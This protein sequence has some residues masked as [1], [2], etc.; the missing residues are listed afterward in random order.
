MEQGRGSLDLVV[1]QRWH[2]IGLRLNLEN[3]TN[4][5]YLFTQGTDSQERAQREFKLG[6]TVSVSLSYSLF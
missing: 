4:S 1:S 3:L 6:R 5:E 2:G